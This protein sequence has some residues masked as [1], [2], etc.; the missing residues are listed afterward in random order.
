[1]AVSSWQTYNISLYSLPSGDFLRSFGDQGPDAG[2]F[3]DPLRLC[4]T[5]KDTILV[6]E[7]DNKRVQEVDVFGRHVR[8][9]GRGLFQCG[10]RGMDI[11]AN[12]D[13]LV[14]GNHG[15]STHQLHLFQLESG[16]HIRSFGPHGSLEGQLDGCFGIRFT[17]DET[18]VVVSEFENKRISFFSLAGEYV[19]CIELRFQ[20]WDVAF[21]L[22]GELIVADESESTITFLSPDGL[23]RRAL[24]M[25]WKK[26]HSS[27]TLI[28]HPL[29][30]RLY[31]LDRNSP[32]VHIFE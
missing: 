20:S 7:D 32:T 22:N 6:T 15:S 17:P 29:D 16:T 31:S 19:R 24:S 18:G 3:S 4:F 25:G 10:V 11:N 8:F 12:L 13:L 9:I 2:Y 23:S 14:V 26:S 27:S 28:V 1:M 5:P 30:G 21:S